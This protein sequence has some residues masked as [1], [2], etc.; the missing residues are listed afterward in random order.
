[1]RASV[2]RKI[3]IRHV[4]KM[5]QFHEKMAQFADFGIFSASAVGDC[6][7]DSFRA[8]APQLGGTPIICGFNTGQHGKKN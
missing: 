5:R 7:G 2:S 4:L 1:M 6:N 8:T 3:M